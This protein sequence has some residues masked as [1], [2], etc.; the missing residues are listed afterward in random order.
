LEEG[1]IEG[2]TH[3]VDSKSCDVNNVH[4]DPERRAWN[5]GIGIV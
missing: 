3:A 2:E 1:L 5:H 4:I